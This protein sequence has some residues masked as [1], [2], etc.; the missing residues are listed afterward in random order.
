M[1]PE[2]QAL[3]DK[4]TNLQRLTVLGVVAGKSQRQAYYDAGGRAASDA[5]AD[6]SAAEILSN[7]KVRDFYDSLMSEAT[8]KA[9]IS[10]EYVLSTIKNTIERCAQAEPVYDREGAP[11]GEYKFDATAVLKGAELLGKHLKL[12]TDKV[13]HSSSDGTMSPKGKSLDDFYTSDV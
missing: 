11:T 4:L 9:E 8:K 12:F 3:A 10:A 5:N 6:S 1:T 13:D 2:Q 7:P